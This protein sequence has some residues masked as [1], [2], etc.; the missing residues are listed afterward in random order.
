MP[1]DSLRLQHPSG[2]FGSDTHDDPESSALSNSVNVDYEELEE[3][4][5]KLSDFWTHITDESMRSSAL[6]LVFALILG[7][8][9]GF[10]LNSIF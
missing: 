3:A 6:L 8:V 9:V 2:N 5:W 7:L 1:D 4:E 10:I